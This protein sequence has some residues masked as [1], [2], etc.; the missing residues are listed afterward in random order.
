MVSVPTGLYDLLLLAT[1]DSCEI[2]DDDAETA[3]IHEDLSFFSMTLRAPWADGSV[4]DFSL[5]NLI[6]LICPGSGTGLQG[7]ETEML[8]SDAY[9]YLWIGGGD[10]QLEDCCAVS[11][12]SD[13]VWV[14]PL[15]INPFAMVTDPRA[16]D[17]A[18]VYLFSRSC[19]DRH[20]HMLV[21]SLPPQDTTE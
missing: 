13:G 17:D 12:I 2:K 8:G 7:N 15:N 21:G 10:G 20:I 3:R 1:T 19:V 16:C 5:N 4:A 18:L 9:V 6:P 11:L 14:Q